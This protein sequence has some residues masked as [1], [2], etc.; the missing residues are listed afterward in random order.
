MKR[1]A[2]MT[3]RVRVPAST[4]NLGAGFDCVGVAVDRWLG[5]T[6]HVSDGGDGISIKRSGSTAGIALKAEDDLIHAGFKLACAE[7][8][9]PVPRRIEYE[10]DS[11]IPVARGLGASAAAL[12]AGGFLASSALRLDL[13]RDAI[14]TLCAREEGHPDNAGPAALGGAVL[15]IPLKDGTYSF[16]ELRIDDGIVLVFVIPELEIL[17]ADARAVLPKSLSYST[18]VAAAAKAAALTEGLRSGDGS[19]L[20]YA[21][22][23]VL[24]VPFRRHLIPGYDSVVSAALRAGAY[25]ATLSG[26]GSTLVAIAPRGL[27]SRVGS[28]MK[29][30]WRTHHQTA[31]VIVSES[32]VPG[33]ELE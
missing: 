17:T 21:L 22:E 12:V 31:E 23:D 13:T 9:R 29:V 15:G 19:L 11:T 14:A 24:H 28:A 6:V 7:R 32:A 18:A 3:A 10:V 25:G 30:A 2:A 16:S 26:S 5:V 20:A 1:E 33:A 4:S 8:K 27:G